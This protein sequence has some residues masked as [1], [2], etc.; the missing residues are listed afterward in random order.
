MLSFFFFVSI[1]F[2]ATSRF[3]SCHLPSIHFGRPRFVGRQNVNY[4]SSFALHL[5]F[6]LFT[7]FALLANIRRTN[8]PKHTH[9]HWA[10][11]FWSAPNPLVV[12]RNI[13]WSTEK[14]IDTRLVSHRLTIYSGPLFPPLLFNQNPTR[15][16][17][18]AHFEALHLDVASFFSPFHCLL[19]L[20]S[21]LFTWYNHAWSNLVCIC[22]RLISVALTF[23]AEWVWNANERHCHL[24][25]RSSNKH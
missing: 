20:S 9:T 23:K 12:A 2:L 17:L 13:R 10:R 21:F 3:V 5:G 16:H 22:T 15:P 6:V 8:L 11:H 25:R 14:H 4:S 18:P 19:C 1:F 24:F 7:I